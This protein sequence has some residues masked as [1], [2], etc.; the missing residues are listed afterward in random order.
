MLNWPQAVPDT[1]K[2][3]S[4]RQFPPL[5]SVI[6]SSVTP[7]SPGQMEPGL[8]SFAALS[9]G[10]NYLSAISNLEGSPYFQYSK[11]R[12]WNNFSREKQAFHCPSGRRKFYSCKFFL[13]K[14]NCQ[15]Y[16]C[17]SISLPLLFYFPS[18]LLNLFNKHL[19]SCYHVPGPILSILQMLPHLS[20]TTTL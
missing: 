7:H 6:E 19:N 13:L 2:V 17:I 5:Q 16:Q 3:P 4:K 20:L 18:L 1:E 12:V 14:L 10:D 9:R 15:E 11:G 8:L